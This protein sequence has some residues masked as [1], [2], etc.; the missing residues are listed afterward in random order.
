MGISGYT[1][2]SDVCQGVRIGMPDTAHLHLVM[3]GWVQTFDLLTVWGFLACRKCGFNV[4][5]TEL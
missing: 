5:S 4:R 1:F 3:R 2:D